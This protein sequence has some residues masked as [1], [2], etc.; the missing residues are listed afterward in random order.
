MLRLGGG[1]PRFLI[2]DRDSRHGASFDRRVR[3]FGIKQHAIQITS[4]Q[5][6]RWEMGE[7]CTI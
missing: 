6:S 2:H 3:H 7:I 1:A 4:G 5:G